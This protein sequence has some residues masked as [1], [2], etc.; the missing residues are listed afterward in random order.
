M[1]HQLYFTP[2]PSA[3][4]HTVHGHMKQ[5]LKDQIPSISHRSSLFK[6]IYGEAVEGLRMLMGVPDDFHVL[7]TSSATE[8]W[9]RILQNTVMEHSYHAV[10]GEFSSRF[11]QFAEQMGFQAQKQEWKPGKGVNVEEIQASPSTELIALTLNETSTGAMM[12]STDFS[13][14]R[15][16]FPKALIAVDA[17]SI[18][19]FPEWDYASIDSFYFSVQKGFGLPAGLGVWVISPK[20]LAKA[21]EKLKTGDSIG[22]FRALPG[23]V[24][25]ALEYQTVETPNTL[26]IYLLAKVTGDFNRVGI[27]QIRREMRYKAAVLRNTVNNHPLLQHFVEET[28][29]QSTSVCVAQVAGG[30]SGLLSYLEQKGIIAGSG[31][32]PFKKEHLRMANFP[33][34]SKEQ[35]ELLADHL[36]QWG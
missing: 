29:H 35:I 5:A 9:E 25:K 33:A 16:K 22:T 11:Y 7:F 1:A 4:Y 31:Y 23:M 17:V 21:E 28:K 13:A 26:G 27:A 2:G 19:P 15:R 36:N 8:I 32:G 24:K 34:H 30:S 18:A 10:N 6:Q 3:L 12:E 14:L 20:M